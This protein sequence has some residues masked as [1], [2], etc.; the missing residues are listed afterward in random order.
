[1]HNEKTNNWG[2][3]SY[4][5]ITS[6]ECVCV[7]ACMCV[8]CFISVGFPCA[9]GVGIQMLTFVIKDFPWLMEGEE[10]GVG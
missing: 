10:I 3:S 8:H 2:D 5:G 4:S 9:Y 1:M 7:C 6:V